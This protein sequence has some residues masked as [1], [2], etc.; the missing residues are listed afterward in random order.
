MGNVINI[1]VNIDYCVIVWY[2]MGNSMRNLERYLVR[3]TNRIMR[4][5]FCALML[6]VAATIS[7]QNIHLGVLKGDL[8]QVEAAL[9]AGVSPNE[10][11]LIG[12]APLHVTARSGNIGIA[13]LLLEYGGDI[14]VLSQDGNEDTPL[15]LSVLNGNLQMTDFLLENGADPNIANSFGNT[16]LHD[17]LVT[18][19]GLG[20]R[21][22]VESGADSE[23]LETK[24]SSAL[25]S[26]LRGLLFQNSFAVSLFTQVP[27]TDGSGGAFYPAFSSEYV[28]DLFLAVQF[29]SI[30]S[31]SSFMALGLELGT[32]LSFAAFTENTHL[33][34]PLRVV[35]DFKPIP[36][37]STQV[38]IGTHLIFPNLN[39]DPSVAFRF[40]IGARAGFEVVRKHEIFIDA[41]Y[42]LPL[43]LSTENTSRTQ[44]NAA[45]Q[46][47]SNLRIGAGY[48]YKL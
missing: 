48:R 29:Q 27:F 22:L 41:G 9:E 17:S 13:R 47:A 43:V 30:I 35:V 8:A 16:P 10:G 23:I 34:I 45:A 3:P 40:E 46:S 25:L 21:Q 44:F 19:D 7:A 4:T 11:N 5:A 6:C 18:N 20:A 37:F 42:V 28:R 12:F 36:L 38:Y 2:S 14:N 31:V 32:A 24:Q 39:L 26:L 33:E 15:H 1:I